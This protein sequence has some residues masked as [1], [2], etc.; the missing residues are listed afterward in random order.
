MSESAIEWTER[1]WNPIVGCT[2]KSPGCTH[3]YAMRMAGRLQAM[4]HPS[5][6]GLTQKSKTGAV[7]TGKLALNEKALLAPLKRQKPTTYFVNS[8]GDLFHEDCPTEWID[9]VFAVIKLCNHHTFQILT[10][11]ADRMRDYF[12]SPG[13]RFEKIARQ[14]TDEMLLVGPDLNFSED[15]IRKMVDVQNFP[16]VWLGVSVEDQTRADERIP[17]LLATPAAIRYLSCEPLLGLVDLT[18]V[19]RRDQGPVD[20]LIGFDHDSPAF[21]PNKIDWV[22]AGGESG[23]KARPM[24]PDWARSLRDR[25]AAANVPFFF[26]QWGEWAPDFEE[27][28]DRPIDDAEQS[29]FD[30]CVWDVDLGRFDTTNGSWCDSDQWYFAQ[31]YQEPEQPMT[32]IGKKRAGRLLDGVQHDGVPHGVQG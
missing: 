16:H 5:Y 15:Y 29:R 17:D 3:C 26:K 28:P 18:R 11:R 6:Q 2:I 9:R 1:T 14:V 8:M 32:R 25:C 10:K 31:N 27:C 4:G 12:N 19:E 24:H 7:W 22:I 21:D 23:P 13:E 30:T 20:A